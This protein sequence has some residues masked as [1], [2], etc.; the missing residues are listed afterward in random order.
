MKR[1]TT[2][3]AAGLALTLAACSPPAADK[4]ATHDAASQ[5]TAPAAAPT[6]VHAKGVGE[7]VVLQP[8]YAA[9]TIRHEAI[10][11]YNMG[12]MTMEFTTDSAARLEGLKV[13]DKVAFELK[14]P[15]EIAT[16]EVVKAP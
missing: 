13:G 1:I 9:V 5:A 2:I 10:P 15:T 6:A 11:E 16:I 7:V 3:F 4:A 8:E 14:G 12:A